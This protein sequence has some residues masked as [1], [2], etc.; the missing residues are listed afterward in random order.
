MPSLFN[1][2]NRLK[3][4]P[5]TWDK[6]LC[7]LDLIYPAGIDEKTLKAH[8][9]QPHRASTQTIIEAIETLHRRY[10]PSPFSPHSEALLRL[11][12]SLAVDEENGD[13]EAMRIVLKRLIEQRDWQQPLDR[14]RLHWIL[15]NS[16][17]DLIPCH[18]D[19]R[20]HQALEYCQQQAISHY[21]QAIT[22]ARQHPDTLQQL[23]PTNLFKLQQNVLAC[24]LNALEKTQRSD[25]RQLAS[26]LEQSDFFASSR[27]LL[28]QEPFQWNVSR[29]ALRFAS[30]LK[31]AKQCEF[32]YHH[33]TEHCA[34]FLDP[35]YRPLNTQSLAESPAFAW[36]L[37]QQSQ[38]K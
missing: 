5:W 31:D 17:F 29:N 28:R 24:Y 4:I 23:G 18:R 33:L 25:G 22:I 16:Y 26:Y 12:N 27:Q 6:F 20:R 1:K 15:A 19:R 2:V 36:A 37:Q 32:F 35:H 8:Y 13:T 38:K 30:M 7:E 34:F 3:A 14:I 21:Q 9:K 11:Y 10:F